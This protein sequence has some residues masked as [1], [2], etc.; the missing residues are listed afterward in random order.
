MTHILTGGCACG[1]VRYEAKNEIQF[2]FQCHCRKC[3]RATGGGHA[4]A[5]AVAVA[6]VDFTGLITEYAQGSDVGATT[7]AGFCGT[8]G[9][10]ISSRTERFADRVYIH[11]ATLDVPSAFKPAV[12]VFSSAAQPWDIVTPGLQKAPE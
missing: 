4:S 12:S 3:Q 5:Y 6:D 10:P 11:A 2:S 9:S 7:Y 8:C 1:A